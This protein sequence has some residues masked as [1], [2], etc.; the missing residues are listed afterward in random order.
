MPQG[1]CLKNI[2]IL[3]S[4]DIPFFPFRLGP[5]YSNFILPPLSSTSTPSPPPPF[6]SCVS[7]SPLPP[8]RWGRSPRIWRYV[9]LSII[10]SSDLTL[11][12]LQKEFDPVSELREEGDPPIATDPD[13]DKPEEKKEAKGEDP[14]EDSEKEEDA[15]AQE[16]KKRKKRKKNATEDWEAIRRAVVEASARSAYRG[17]VIVYPDGYWSEGLP[18]DSDLHEWDCLCSRCGEPDSDDSGVNFLLNTWEERKTL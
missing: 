6:P 14:E 8:S 16:K 18:S 9:T 2:I 5:F 17:G 1:H 3:H 7:S 13:K 4:S 10:P 12:Y 11:S 15:T